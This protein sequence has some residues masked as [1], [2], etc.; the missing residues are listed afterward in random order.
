M[1]SMFRNSSITFPAGTIMGWVHPWVPTQFFQMSGL[2]MHFRLFMGTGR[3]W[4]WQFWNN[5]AK[6]YFLPDNQMF[7]Q[8]FFFLVNIMKVNMLE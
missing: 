4:V 8:N 6:S 3:A 1:A 5:V 2:G 7:N